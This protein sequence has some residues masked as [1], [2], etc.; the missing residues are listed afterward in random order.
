L[1]LIFCDYAVK[2]V[3][4]N[5]SKM[6]FDEIEEQDG[7]RFSWNVFPASRLDATRTVVPISCLY[8]PL[9]ERED[10]PP[11]YYEPVTCKAPCRAI[12]NPYW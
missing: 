11:I 10:L 7:T 8:T 1:K 3:V 2:K 5:L 6:N 4:K 12:L 9:R